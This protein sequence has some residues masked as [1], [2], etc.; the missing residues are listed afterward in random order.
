MSVNKKEIKKGSPFTVRVL[1]TLKCH[2]NPS[3]VI[4][5]LNKPQ[6]VTTN[7]KG[8]ILVTEGEAHRVS[9]FNREGQ[10]VAIGQSAI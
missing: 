10:F 6:G 8:N 1:P 2:A 3:M 4:T 7:I 9:A 5:G